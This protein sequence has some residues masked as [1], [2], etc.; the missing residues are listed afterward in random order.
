MQSETR[1]LPAYW[2]PYLINGDATGMEWEEVQEVEDFLERE[3]LASP[4][5][6]EFTGFSW[7]NDAN[8]VGGD[9][10][11]FTFIIT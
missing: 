9:V 4:V 6:C 1:T 10:A 5:D 11:D 8:A 2:A 7:M 3:G